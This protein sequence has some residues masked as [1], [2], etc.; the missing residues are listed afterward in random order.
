MVGEE[1]LEQYINVGLSLGCNGF[2][3]V[4]SA[5]LILAA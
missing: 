3:W 1:N 2:I 4:G 5:L